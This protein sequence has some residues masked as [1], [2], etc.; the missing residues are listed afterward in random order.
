MT[1]ELPL[2]SGLTRDLAIL[3]PLAL[4][5]ACLIT[6]MAMT[7]VFSSKPTRRRAAL[8]VLELLLPGRWDRKR[9]RTPGRGRT[10]RR[11]RDPPTL[12]PPNPWCFGIT[13]HTFPRT[14]ALWRRPDWR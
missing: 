11:R 13:S 6:T 9:D 12:P 14:C 7:A 8:E 2:L 3:A 4:I 5:Y 1:A 10:I